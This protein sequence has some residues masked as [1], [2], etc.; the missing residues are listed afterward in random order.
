MSTVI[1]LCVPSSQLASRS[2][3][4]GYQVYT[5]DLD[6]GIIYHLSCWLLLAP[7]A[8]L[9]R[10]LIVHCA[11]MLIVDES[12]TIL[13]RKVYNSSLMRANQASGL[14][15]TLSIQSVQPTSRGRMGLDSVSS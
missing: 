4:R 1:D 11:T 6:R 14:A 9:D 7:A 13:C 10:Y 3:S 8:K 15:V 2:K 5:V 12:L